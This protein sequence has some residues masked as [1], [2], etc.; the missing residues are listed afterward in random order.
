[1]PRRM[2]ER[3]GILALA[4]N[5]AALFAESMMTDRPTGEANVESALAPGGPRGNVP[6]YAPFFGLTE[7]PFDLTPNPRF[8]FL[9][10][11]HR[12][13]L[14][15]LRLALSSSRGFTLVLGDAGTGKTTLARTALASIEGTP[16]LFAVLNNP[17]LSRDEFYQFLTRA[18]ALG[19]NA[20][21][22]KSSF[23]VELESAVEKRFAAGGLTGLVVDEAQSLSFEL[24][25]EIRLLGNIETATTKLLNIILCGQ[26]ELAQRLNDP[27]LRQLKQRVALRCELAPLSLSETASYISGRLRI[28]G[29]S[30]AEIFTRD[31]V[32]AI[33]EASRGIPRTINVV[34]DNA[35]LGGLAA[36]TKPVTA[37]IV[38]EVVV[39]FD[40][41]RQGDASAEPENG[42]HD[43][44]PHAASARPEP[45][46]PAVRTQVPP[47]STT[48]RRFS[49]F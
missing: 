39:D 10:G 36:Q 47:T 43:Q 16:S 6:I 22:S 14:A 3:P 15:S 41:R 21:L 35:L 30:P 44:R 37:D 9:T 23:L 18:F 38:E 45:T 28:A 42:A 17:T 19:P 40:L 27:T 5:G 2:R 7:G 24:L 33:Y 20:A 46:V 31:A 49:F 8:V 29:G 11:R 48:K 1:M 13:A 12:E 25:E 26:P 34:C 32:V 4:L